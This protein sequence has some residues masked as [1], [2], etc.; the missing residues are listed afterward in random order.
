M[1]TDTMIVVG[2]IAW[3]ERYNERTKLSFGLMSAIGVGAC[4]TGKKYSCV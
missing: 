4:H 2:I 1:T 3:D